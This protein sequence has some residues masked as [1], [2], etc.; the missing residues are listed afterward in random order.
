MVL[1]ENKIKISAILPRKFL[2][3]EYYL[4][5]YLSNK[6]KQDEFD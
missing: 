5:K 6:E 4:S 2:F 1:N 3:S